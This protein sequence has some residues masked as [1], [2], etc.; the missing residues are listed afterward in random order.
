MISS[1]GDAP[2]ALVPK[3]HFAMIHQHFVIINSLLKRVLDE[4]EFSINTFFKE[5]IEKTNLLFSSLVVYDSPYYFHRGLFASSK[6]F[7]YLVHNRMTDVIIRTFE[8]EIWKGLQADCS[9]L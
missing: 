9:V 8:D 4:K 6:V 5:D 1:V 3:V 7:D 2:K